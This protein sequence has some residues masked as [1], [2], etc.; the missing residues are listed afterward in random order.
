MELLEVY[1]DICEQKTLIVSSCLALKGVSVHPDMIERV[2]S[3]KKLSDFT[4]NQIVSIFI[5]NSVL[6]F[7]DECEKQNYSEMNGTL[8]LALSNYLMRDI[9]V[10]ESFIK[11]KYTPESICSK[12]DA[13]FSLRKEETNFSSFIK[14]MFFNLVNL[15]F[16]SYDN[17]IFIYFL[18]VFYFYVERKQVLVY[19]T[20]SGDVQASIRDL[21]N[22]IVSLEG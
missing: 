20:G 13:I 12:L 2:F 15:D 11:D 3:G 22:F 9:S 19:A 18:V 10:R 4:Y 5:Y 16:L 6:D 1:K 21:T 8:A 14:K 7:I 17:Y